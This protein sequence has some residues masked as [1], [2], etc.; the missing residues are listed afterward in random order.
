MGVKLGFTAREEQRLRIFE[1][2]VPRRIFGC[3][4]EGG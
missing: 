3:S 4:D 1:T 2:M